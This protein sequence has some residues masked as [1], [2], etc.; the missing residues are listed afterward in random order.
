[1]GFQHAIRSFEELRPVLKKRKMDLGLSD[2]AVDDLAGL[3]NG[4]F[5]KVVNGVKNPGAKTLPL[6]LSALRLEL[7]VV[8]ATS[9]NDDTQSKS[10]TYDDKLKKILSDRGIKGGRTRAFRAGKAG[11]S[12]MARKGGLARAKAMRAAKKGRS[13]KA[14]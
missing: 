12:A 10:M 14:D 5:G 3:Q 7:H 2:L 9:S 6:I 1:M 8:P 13:K 4:Y 11:M